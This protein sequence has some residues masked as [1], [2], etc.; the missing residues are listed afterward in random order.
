MDLSMSGV[1]TVKSEP[2]WFGLERAGGKPNTLRVGTEDELVMCQQ[3]H[4]IRVVETGPV[5]DGGQPR[6][7]QRTITDVSDVTGE[8]PIADTSWRSHVILISWEA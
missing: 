4:T 5:P 3:A 6:A 7:F 1:L 2:R 8:L